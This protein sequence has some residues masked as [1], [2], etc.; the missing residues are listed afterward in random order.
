MEV[1]QSNFEEQL[2][3]VKDLLSRASFVAL[4][5]EFSGKTITQREIRCNVSV[6]ISDLNQPEAIEFLETIPEKY[7]RTR[8][9]LVQFQLLQIGLAIFIQEPNEQKFGAQACTAHTH[10]THP[11]FLF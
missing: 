3:I 7:A 8:E 1:L 5:T 11:S 10:R 6:G 2:A 9:S 4:D